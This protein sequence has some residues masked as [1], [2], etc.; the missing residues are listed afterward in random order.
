MATPLSVGQWPLPSWGQLTMAEQTSAE[1]LKRAFG[2]F[3]KVPLLFP[4]PGGSYTLTP[5]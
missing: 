3:D 5:L 4:H 1:D 2:I